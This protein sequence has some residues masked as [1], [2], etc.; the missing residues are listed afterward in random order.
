MKEV[1][2][3]VVLV[4]VAGVAAGA[5]ARFYKIELETLQKNMKTKLKNT[6]TASK[7]LFVAVAAFAVTASGVHAFGSTELLVKAGLN[8]DQVV[9]V[10]EA[11]E[12]KATGDIEGA[13]ATLESAGITKQTM[14]QIREVAKEAKQAVH[15]AVEANDYD[16]FV[17]AV[18]DSPLA[19]VI[20]N[21]AEFDQFVEAHELKESGDRDGAKE[22]LA[23]LGVDTEK[24]SKKHGKRGMR[25]EARELLSD[26]Q[27]EAL[28]VAHAAN[29]REAVR[30]IFAEAGID[31]PEKG[32][33]RGR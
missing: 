8:E 31:L 25:A 29:D 28:Q 9:A 1:F 11:Q 4:Y 15:A 22:I 10:Q 2:L 21:E 17:V 27:R 20:T 14:Q 30:A 32:S 24:H 7:S 33:K 3:S 12:L 23:E 19:D 6:S 13:K 16:A 18:A 26:D 5:L